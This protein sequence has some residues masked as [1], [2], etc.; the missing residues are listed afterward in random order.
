[1]QTAIITLKSGQKYEI[2]FNDWDGP[3]SVKGKTEDILTLKEVGRCQAKAGTF[4]DAT[5]NYNGFPVKTRSLTVT[6]LQNSVKLVYLK[7]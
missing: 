7:A 6:V 1:M 5:I 2:S 3:N 4:E